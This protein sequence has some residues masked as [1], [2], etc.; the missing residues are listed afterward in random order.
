MMQESTFFMRT[1]KAELTSAPFSFIPWAR[2]KQIIKGCMQKLQERERSRACRSQQVLALIPSGQAG[3]PGQRP[4]W[5]PC[6]GA[7]IPSLSRARIWLRP[8]GW[9]FS[10]APHSSED[11][12][13]LPVGDALSSVCWLSLSP[14]LPYYLTF[15]PQ[16][17]HT[18]SWLH[19]FSTV[20]G[21]HVLIRVLPTPLL[22][23]P[24]I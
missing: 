24:I 10:L 11:K 19:E 13:S 20:S 8:S 1:R 2:S 7:G 22:L 17:H 23:P 15:T 18:A 6:L 12:I 14:V 16:P 5:L 9:K 21:H 3:L 4:H